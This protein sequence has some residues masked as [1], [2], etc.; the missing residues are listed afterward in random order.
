VALLAQVIGKKQAAAE[1]PGAGEGLDDRGTAVVTEGG[2]SS[3]FNPDPGRC[4]G[5]RRA[6]FQRDPARA[7]TRKGGGRALPRNVSF[8]S[9]NARLRLTRRWA[10]KGKAFITSAKPVSLQSVVTIDGKNRGQT[11]KTPG[12][13]TDRL[14]RDLHRFSPQ[15]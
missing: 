5:D 12:P 6:E 10:A 1:G 13:M 7:G 14:P 11:G 15:R 4:A 8:A 2:S 3:A 9:R